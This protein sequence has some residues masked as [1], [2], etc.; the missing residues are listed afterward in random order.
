MTAVHN[1]FQLVHATIM[2]RIHC[3]VIRREAS[4]NASRS[5]WVGSAISA[6][7]EPTASS[8]EVVKA[9][10]DSFFIILENIDE[11]VRQ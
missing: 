2:A 3:C 7:R 10:E 11:I 1:I 9:S 4:A 6:S 8:R 5:P